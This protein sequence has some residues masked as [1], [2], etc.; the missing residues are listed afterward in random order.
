MLKILGIILGFIIMA[1]SAV[2]LITEIEPVFVA[3]DDLNGPEE[4]IEW[5]EDAAQMP[6]LN[7]GIGAGFALDVVPEITADE[8][9]ELPEET[10]AGPAAGTGMDLETLSAGIGAAATYDLLKEEDEHGG[11]S[12]ITFGDG[13]SMHIPEVTIL[14][15]GGDEDDYSIMGFAEGQGPAF[16]IRCITPDPA[17]TFEDLEAICEDLYGGSESVTSEDLTYLTAYDAVT[18]TQMCIFPS[19][20]S[21]QVYIISMTGLSDEQPAQWY[22]DT[23]Q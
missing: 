12:V 15:D 14:A 8:D 11:G 3:P 5:E 23:I 9:L 22:F 10:W 7:A 18:D 20:L 19:E 13:Y 2:G 17:L 4:V 21:S 16:S 6:E 1:I